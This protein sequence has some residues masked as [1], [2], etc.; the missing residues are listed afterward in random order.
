[1]FCFRFNPGLSPHFLD[2]LLKSPIR[3]IVI[4]ALGAGNLAG[5]ENSMI[6]WIDQMNNSGKIVVMNS[7]SDYGYVDLSLY[8]SGKL[9]EKAGAISAR[10]MTT[11]TTIGKLMHLMGIYKNDTMKIKADLSHSLAGEIT[12]SER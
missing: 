8:E 4:E 9:A 6:P 7:Q 3:A 2:Y 10:D 11:A 5:K 1:M 12:E